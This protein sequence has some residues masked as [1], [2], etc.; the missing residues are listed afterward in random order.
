MKFTNTQIT[1]LISGWNYVDLEAL[2]F[3][4]FNPLKQYH[5]W[6]NILPWILEYQNERWEED[7]PKYGMPSIQHLFIYLCVC[8]IIYL[9]Y[10]VA[11][12][13]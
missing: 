9:L 3:T 6:D 13:K 11:E 2:L 7:F 10:C 8:F 4:V 5:P 12:M 1:K